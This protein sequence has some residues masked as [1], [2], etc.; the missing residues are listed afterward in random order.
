MKSI[1]CKMERI[2]WKDKVTNDQVLE[3]VKEKRTP[4]DVIRSR[5][6]KWIGHVL[7]GNG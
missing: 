5:K 1:D 4:I 3:I 2:G 6:K 7:T